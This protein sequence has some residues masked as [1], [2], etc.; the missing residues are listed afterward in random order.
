LDQEELAKLLTVKPHL[1]LSIDF[2]R[3]D[4]PDKN[5]TT[6]TMVDHIPAIEVIAQPASDRVALSLGATR[7]SI[8]A[9]NLTAGQDP[10]QAAMG[11]QLKLMVHDQSDPLV[12]VLDANADGRLGEREIAS[13]AKRLLDFDA[14]KNGQ[15][16]TNELP[17][18]MVVAFLR[19]EQ[20]GEQSFYRPQSARLLPAADA[21]S[22]FSHAD[23]NGDG[24]V[25]R[26]EFLGSGEQFS[27]LDSNGD[28]FISAGEVKTQSPAGG[29]PPQ[30]D[31]SN[32]EPNHQP[33]K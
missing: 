12:E 32:G 18:S 30:T 13:G 16:D 7:L 19:G 21:P 9:H 28:G 27:K 17:Y 11:S 14:N 10:A 2:S 1:K 26:R 29:N 33:A 23:F 31:A 24:D 5:K 8:S 15:V 25:S 4:T 22:W 6:L 20:P 3:G